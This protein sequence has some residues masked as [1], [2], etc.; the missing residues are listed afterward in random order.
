MISLLLLA[1]TLAALAAS[2]AAT[3]S[4]PLDEPAPVEASLPLAALGLS[5]RRLR[6]VPTG[7]GRRVLWAGD[8]DVSRYTR[9]YKLCRGALYDAGFSWGTAERSGGQVQPLCWENPGLPEETVAAAIA[10]AE[11]ALAE[12]DVRI[13]RQRRDAELEASLSG[14]ARRADMESLRASLAERHWAWPKRKRGV[15]EALLTEAPG[16]GGVPR[17]GAAKVARDLVAEIE[18]AIAAVRARVAADP[19]HDWLARAEDPAV[20]SAVLTATRILSEMDED[21]ASIDNGIG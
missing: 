5:W 8:G 1:L 3:A 10:T 4:H 13:E 9:A 20:R 19:V 15:A 12:D 14:D 11:A 6:E 7:R 2:V 16:P 21:R 17:A 18:A